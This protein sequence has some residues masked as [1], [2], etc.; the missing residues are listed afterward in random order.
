MRRNVGTSRRAFLRTTGIAGATAATLGITGTGLAFA[1]NDNS[2][3]TPNPDS[4]QFTLAVMPDTQY[5]YF[6]DSRYPDVQQAAFRYIVNSPDNIV[7]LAHL[8]DLTEDGLPSEFASVD[9]AFHYL[10]QHRVAYSVLAGNHDVNS[11]TNDQRGATPYLST[12]GP[13]RFTHSPSFRGATPDGY[14]TYHVFHAAGRDWLVLALDWRP[15]PG[16]FAWANDVIKRNP[17][18][19]VIL[20][21][22]E[23]A[24]PTYDSMFDPP[25]YGNPDDNAVLSGFGHQLWDELIKNNDQIVLSLSGHNWPPGRTVLRNAAG[26]DVHIHVADY[27]NRYFGGAAMIRLY[28]FDLTRNVI[29][30]ETLSPWVQAQDPAQRN[31]LAQQVAE[32]TSP[33]DAFS[34]PFDFAQRFAGFAPV[35]PVPSRPAHTMLVPGTVAYWRFDTKNPDGTPYQAGATIPDQSGQGNDLTTLVTVPGS[36]TDTLT[37]SDDHHPDQPGHGSLRFTGGQNPLHG[38][39]LTTSAT[40]PLNT[41]TFA[42][43]YTFEAFFKLPRDFNPDDNSWMAILSRW[44]ESGQ[45]GK[46]AGNTDPQEPI[47]TLSISNGRALQWCVYPLNLD[48]Q[49]T[50]WGH[51]LPADKWWHVAV[52]NDGRH[53]KMY[54]DGCVVVDNPLDV[55][56]GLTQLNLPWVLGGYEYGGTI[57]QIFNGWIGD[58]RIVNRPL[59]TNQF[60]INHR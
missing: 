34:M 41:A 15:S 36:A 21:T 20:T 19:P 23:T 4:P 24:A 10:D 17:H 16:G 40:A 38:A 31:V 27:Q 58:V 45:A 42:Q 52:V 57:N 25:D 55:T 37:W 51:E 13:Q 43:G 49:S 44:G 35:P 32:L 47:A 2:R 59:S 3:W 56:V 30:V 48:D 7:F 26:N 33:V 6:D 9:T 5:L 14:N 46:S 8:G 29:D 11:S 50:N 39:Y 22:H 18:L 53:T 12:M 54:V 1:D 28:H 60:M